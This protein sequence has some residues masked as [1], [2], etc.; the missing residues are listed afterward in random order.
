[1]EK[2]NGGELSPIQEIPAKF[3]ELTDDAVA[4]SAITENLF[5]SG[6]D[7]ED[8]VNQRIEEI[9]NEAVKNDAKFR[10]AKLY[11]EV[12]NDLDSALKKVEEISSLDEQTRCL[13]HLAIAVLK[14]EGDSDLADQIVAKSSQDS[15]GYLKFYDQEKAKIVTEKPEI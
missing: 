8:E 14:K 15:E 1:M 12:E 10:I 3:K 9:E 6:Q 5:L 13:V 4:N 11:Y 2:R 7:G